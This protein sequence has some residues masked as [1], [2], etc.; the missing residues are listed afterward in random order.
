MRRADRLFQI[1]QYLRGRRLTTA[2]Q[3]AEWL[4]VTPRTIYRDIRDLLLSGV[5]IE[6]EAG[7]GYRMRPGFDLPPLM[8]TF[9]EIEAIVAGTRMVEA[10]GSPELANAGRS[11]L[12]KIAGALPPSR[13]DELDR[14]RLFAMAFNADPAVSTRLETIRQ[15]IARRRVLEIDYRDAKDVASLR[16]VR[17]LGLYFWG[18]VWTLGAW[19]ETRN[20]FRNFRLD[21]M[22]GIAMTDRRFVEERGKSLSDFLRKMRES[23]AG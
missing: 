12:A 15:S 13:R 20:D 23:G 4:E 1:A 21:R 8:F 10:W 19:C 5:P 14:P 7:V 3:L 22:V 18:K 2:A 6:G 11:A 16:P 17:P 9:D